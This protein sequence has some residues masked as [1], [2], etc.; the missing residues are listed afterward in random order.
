[1]LTRS[2]RNRSPVEGKPGHPALCVLPEIEKEDELFEII[3]TLREDGK[4]S[5]ENLIQSC[6]VEGCENILLELVKA[7]WIDMKDD[8][9]ELI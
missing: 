5:R 2:E 4:L 8:H 1:M 3:W 6:T 7:G 9:I